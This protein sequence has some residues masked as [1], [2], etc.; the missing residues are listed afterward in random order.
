MTIPDTILD[1]PLVKIGIY[2]Y[3]KRKCGRKSQCDISMSEIARAFSLTRPTASRYVSE[4]ANIGALSLIGHQTDTKRTLISLKTNELDSTRGHQT[5]TKRTLPER[6]KSFA[7]SLKTY[8]PKY[9]RDMLNAFYQYWTQSNDGR[10]MLFERQQAFELPNRLATW[11]SRNASR[12]PQADS[13]HTDGTIL[14]SEQMDY[15][16]D[17][18]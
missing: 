5:D 16:K 17:L 3:I 8:L 11:H 13:L 4:L 14:H 1:L 10:R 7:E 12:A 15:S 2:I 6:K 9:G 18:W